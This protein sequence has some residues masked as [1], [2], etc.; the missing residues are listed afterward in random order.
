MAIERQYRLSEAAALLGLKE[1]TLRKWTLLRRIRTT[2]M[3]ASR[4]VPESEIARI[5]AQGAVP[6]REERR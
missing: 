3:G 2:K 5:I 1:S 4:R 6:A